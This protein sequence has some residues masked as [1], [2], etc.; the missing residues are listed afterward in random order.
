[1][2]E[3]TIFPQSTQILTVNIFTEQLIT[4]MFIVRERSC[5]KDRRKHPLF[6][7]FCH[8]VRC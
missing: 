1:M 5:I 4:E 7:P 6:H 8:F 2:R 3:N